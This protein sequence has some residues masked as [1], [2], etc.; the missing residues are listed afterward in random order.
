MGDDYPPL[1]DYGLIGDG[2]GAALSGR[3]G[4]IDWACLRRFDAPPAFA[5]LLDRARGGS[6]RVAPAEPRAESSQS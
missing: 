1:A 5:A 2:R 6:W 4:S 3:R